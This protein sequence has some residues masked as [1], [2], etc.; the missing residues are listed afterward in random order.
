MYRYM[1]T[2]AHVSMLSL[3]TKGF[4]DDIW[5]LH[6]TPTPSLYPIQ[7]Q[8]DHV[9]MY[10]FTCIP[11]HNSMFKFVVSM[12]SRLAFSVQVI[13]S[14]YELIFFFFVTKKAGTFS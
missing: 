10:V 8:I 7:T 2:P 14:R 13:F 12:C 1:F 6:P 4:K 9:H 11:E 3:L 5:H